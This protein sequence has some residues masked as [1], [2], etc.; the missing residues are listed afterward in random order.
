MEYTCDECYEM[1]QPH[2]CICNNC[3]KETMVSVVSGISAVSKCTNCGWGCVSAGGFPPSCHEDDKLYSLII[4]RPEDKMKM[5]KLSN[6]LSVSV[7]DLIAEFQNE[8][9]ERKYSVLECLARYQQLKELDIKCEI[10]PAIV[11]KFIRIM[12]CEYVGGYDIRTG[13]IVYKIFDYFE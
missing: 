13:T 4:Y 12:K 7:M 3:G 6:S 10:D 5:V 8:M 1:R 9:I 11:K 2:I